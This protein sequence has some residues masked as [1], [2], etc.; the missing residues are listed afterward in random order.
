M[1]RRSDARERLLTAADQLFRNR[2]FSSV[3]VAELCAE[4]G[5]NKGSFY[6]FFPSKRS[7]LLEVVEAAWDETGMLRQWEAEPPHRPVDALRSFFEELF[8]F[9]YADQE[10][11]GRVRG[12]LLANLSLELG[13]QDPEVGDKVNE[14]LSRETRAFEALISDALDRGQV[15]LGSPLHAAEALVGCLH[16]LLMLARARNDLSVLPDA[17][18]EL[19]RLAGVTQPWL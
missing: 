19:L 1:G 14:L 17:E 11:S 16:G 15:S 6:H 8:A 18:N 9:H 7:L 2:G 3:G 10:S 12:S 13:P 4:A 5:V